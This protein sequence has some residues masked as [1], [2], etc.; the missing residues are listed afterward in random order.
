MTNLA[1]RNFMYARLPGL[2]GTGG[3]AAFM[4]DEVLP[5][6]PAYRWTLNHVVEVR[7]PLE[8]FRIEIEEVS[9]R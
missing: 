8:L 7:D 5:A 1:G 6:R 3:A 2:R 4:S 9:G